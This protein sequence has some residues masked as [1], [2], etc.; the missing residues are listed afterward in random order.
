VGRCGAGEKL[1]NVLLGQIQGGSHF[2]GFLA[3]TL[4]THKFKH[5]IYENLSN[6]TQCFSHYCDTTEIQLTGLVTFLQPL[7]E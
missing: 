3:T 4:G 1:T 5:R 6:I 7:I 2:E